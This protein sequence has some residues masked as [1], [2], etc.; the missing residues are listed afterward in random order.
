MKRFLN[1]FVH[2]FEGIIRTIKEERNIKIHLLAVIVVISMGLIYKISIV[3][4]MICLVLFGLV[5]STEIINTSIERAVDLISKEKMELIKPTATLINTSRIDIVDMISLIEKAEKY[6][7]FYVGLDIDTE[8][9][10]EQLSKY[11][12]NVL[13]TPHTAG[14]SKEAIDRMDV[15]LVN[16]IVEKIK[17]NN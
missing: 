7:S 13:I 16:K 15:E 8:E 9:Y 2:A 1:S 4:W 11:R 3:E 10:E 6:P 17:E 14:V 5:I 12:R